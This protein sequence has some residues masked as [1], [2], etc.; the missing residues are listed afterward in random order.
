MPTRSPAARR[1][2]RRLSDSN[3]YIYDPEGINLN[4][5]RQLKEVE[6]KRIKDYV[7]NHK[8]AKYVEG[9]DGIWTLKCDV[10]LPC[11]TQNELDEK[12]A[13]TLVEQRLYAVAE[14]A[15]MPS[16]PEA[17]Q[18]LPEEQGRLWSRQSGQRRRRG[19]LRPGNGP[20][21][22]RLS[23][24]FEETDKKLHGIME[25]IH[26]GQ[27]SRRRIRHPGQPGQRRQHRRL[28]EGRPG[29]DGPGPGIDRPLHFD[30]IN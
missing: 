20:E 2:G 26:S 23:W 1:Q 24:T 27:E 8:P 12:A 9:C 3:G 16:T 5:V 19:H 17:D 22:P 4:T 25:N 18:G 11:A 29:H 28:R 14:G 6:R 30:S 10:A 7:K 15:N 21:R 13:E